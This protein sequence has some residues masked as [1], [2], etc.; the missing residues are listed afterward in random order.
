MLQTYHQQ[1]WQSAFVV[2]PGELRLAP[3]G[4]SLACIFFIINGYLL[5]QEELRQ[6]DR[7]IS[8]TAIDILG[9]LAHDQGVEHQ[10][11]FSRDSVGPP[12]SNHLM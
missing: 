7:R 6:G 8:D 12:H 11:L 2:L 1:H 9:S 4:P 5:L 3:H 10:T